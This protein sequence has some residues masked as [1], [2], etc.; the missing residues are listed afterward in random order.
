M[1]E[2]PGMTDGPGFGGH[3]L[4]MDGGDIPPDPGPGCPPWV[5]PRQRPARTAELGLGWALLLS[6]LAGLVVPVMAI[7]AVL[8]ERGK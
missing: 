6:P 1:P 7:S 5:Y 4:S 8:R 3:S 2:R